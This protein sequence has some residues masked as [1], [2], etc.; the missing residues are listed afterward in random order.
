MI[1]VTHF[2][3]RP[4]LGFYSIERL[5]A[6][7]RTALPADIAVD[8]RVSR[9][10]SHGFWR[11]IFD[12]LNAQRYQGDVNH[13]LGDVHFLTL[14]LDPRRTIL[15]IHD[16]VALER[17]TGLKRWVYW[18][19]WFWLAEKRCSAIVVVS[20]ATRDQVLALPGVFRGGEL[21]AW[22]AAT[23]IAFLSILVLR[24]PSLVR[25]IGAGLLGALLIGAILLTGRRKMLMALTLFFTFQWVLIIL[26]RQGATRLS[27][28]L[29]SLALT[30]A[31][32]F[33]FLGHEEADI[34]RATYVD[35]GLTV[36]ESTGER[37]ETTMN[38]VQSAW[39]RSRGLGVGAGVAGQGGRYAGGGGAE[40]VGGAA[41]AGLGFIIVELGLPG[42][43]AMVW[44]MFLL[45]RRLW[46]GLRL[47]AWVNPPLLVYAV[48]F[49]A[50]LMANLA[51]FGVAVQLFSDYAVLI[52]LGLTA[53]MLF[54]LIDAGIQDY[55]SRLAAWH[56]GGWLRAGRSDVRA[57]A[58]AVANAVAVAN[59]N[60]DD[61]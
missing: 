9:F 49:A 57:D 34:Q 42:V 40:A 17:L 36:F 2:L 5:Y 27:G 59:A 26:L 6:D 1:R 54:A 53:G 47:L 22:H 31:V 10:P 13:V 58:D 28:A 46:Q 4:I 61:A 37:W 44:L 48:S 43:L 12:T 30:L 33:S 60:A 14:L 25:I 3:R 35:R 15:T 38:L 8:V 18:M 24:R 55:G 16:C 52:T 39:Y 23:S 21:A 32:G 50:L 20:T 7:V 51:T 41:E 19:L 11:R 29:L 56:A 45:V